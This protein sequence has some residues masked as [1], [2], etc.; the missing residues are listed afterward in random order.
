MNLHWMDEL[1]NQKSI[2][3]IGRYDS[4]ITPKNRILFDGIYYNIISVEDIR[5]QNKF[6]KINA[7]SRE[8]GQ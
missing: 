5:R 8:D 7:V 1:K 2:D 4:S 3:L 6:L